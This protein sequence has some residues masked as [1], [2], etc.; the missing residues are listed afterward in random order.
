MRTEGF[1]ITDKI[2]RMVASIREEIAGYATLAE[3]DKQIAGIPAKMNEPMQLAIVGKISSSKS[4][5]VNAILG[6]AEIV[7]TGEREETWNVSWLKYGSPDSPVIVHYK[8]ASRKPEK[9]ERSRW[10]EWANRKREDSEQLKN[11][12]SYIEVT[13]KHKILEKINIIDTPGLSSFYGADSQNTKDFLQNEQPDAIIMLFAKNMNEDTLRDIEFFRQDIGAGFSP[14][15]AIGMLSKIDDF[16]N[17]DP[18][19]EPLREGQKIL[20]NLMAKEIIKN[21]LF[22]IYPVSA[23]TALAASG[24]TEQ[25][26]E[27]MKNISALP[28]RVQ[29][30]LFFTND[31]FLETDIPV[32]VEERKR[33]LSAYGRYGVWL[34]VNH[35]KEAKPADIPAVRDWLLQKSGFDRFS[36]VLQNHFVQQ[37]SVIKVYKMA[38]SLSQAIRKTAG[39]YPNDSGEKRALIKVIHEMDNLIRLIKIQTGV[40]DISKEYYDGKLDISLEEFEE[41]RRVNGEFGYSCIERT[42]L[43]ENAAPQEMINSCMERI[44]YW[45]QQL[46]EQGYRFPSLA[47]FMKQMVNSYWVLQNDIVSAKHK[48]E[49]SARFLF[50]K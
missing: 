13:Y 32:S 3:L 30:N 36:E 6:E 22:A 31:D 43:N 5:L 23:F 17:S 15:N 2:N 42:G 49:A 50:G 48:M 21:I 41:L 35:L 20:N 8:D 47:R 37:S 46:N 45:N 34:I 24:I 11:A 9:I 27:I 40:I 4:T 33:L 12:V 14:V 25:D 39:I 44:D 28:D 18:K 10:A 29:D 19:L 1:N 16:W 26:M 38:S 7:R